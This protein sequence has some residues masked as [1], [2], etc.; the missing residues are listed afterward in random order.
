MSYLSS[1]RIRTKLAC[2]CVVAAFAL[3][4]SIGVGASML[5]TRMM[6]DRAA[7][8]R[9]VVLS[10]IGFAQALEREVA[11][12][13]MARAQALD[14]FR[15]ALHVMRFGAEDDY[16]LVQ[17]PDG[18]VLI[19]GGDP[20]REG[21]PTASRDAAGRSSAELAQKMLA[22]DGDRFGGGVIAYQ[23]LKPGQTVPQDKLTYVAAYA[24]WRIVV[25]AGAWT[26]D[27]D[28]AFRSVL[29]RLTGIGGGVLV[30][31]LLLAWRINSDIS[32]S[33]ARLQSAMATLAQGDL[34][35]VIPGHDRKDEVGAMAGAVLV[36]QQNALE[37]TQLRAAQAAASVEAAAA[38]RRARQTL[39]AEFEAD[40]GAIVD[41]VAQSATHMQKAASGMSDRMDGASARALDVAAA[42]EQA[43]VNVQA[44]AGAAEELA[45][46]IAEISR[47]VDAAAACAQ[48]AATLSERSGRLVT[49]LATAAQSIDAVTSMISTIASQ[50]NLLALNATIEAARAGAA[51]KGFAVVA[52][53]VKS[54]ATRTGHATEDISRHIA[55]MQG[56]TDDTVAAIREIGTI[57]G[58]FTEIATTIAAAVEQQGAATRE[59]ARNVQEA[60]QGTITVSQSAGAVRQD[61]GE[62]GQE[63]NA[64]RDTA[65]GLSS[66]A[67]KLSNQVERFITAVRAA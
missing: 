55:A 21:K 19:H 62:A 31:A 29:L 22:H 49:G 50:T 65:N 45:S 47:Q 35:V 3:V 64:V 18:L 26:D 63:A 1:V 46:S 51:G 16:L 61:V 39:A 9:A 4:A 53:E 36:F 34:S 15:D 25:M 37:V 57:V 58:Q 27:V 6:A 17:D 66:E 42:S 60:A 20:K 40:V 13:H 5:H 56:A 14:R 24:P 30:V 59:I 28:A 8:L 67:T 23:A 43:S 44:V 52:T 33:M 11:S 32:G 48:H 7:Q 54:L 41:A 12:G 38:A 2:V 10:A